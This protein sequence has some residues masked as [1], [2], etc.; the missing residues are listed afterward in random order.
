MPPEQPRNIL[1]EVELVDRANPYVD[2]KREERQFG[3]ETHD[4]I[5]GRVAK[6]TLGSTTVLH[7][8]GHGNSEVIYSGDGPN[9]K[10]FRVTPFSPEARNAVPMPTT[11]NVQGNHAVLPAN[12][13]FGPDGLDKGDDYT[14][15]NR[16]W[17]A[18]K[19][20]IAKGPRT[21][22]QFWGNKPD[23][24]SYVHGP[25]GI[26]PTDAD[27]EIETSTSLRAA[28]KTD[29]KD[30]EGA[31]KQDAETTGQVAHEDIEAAE[32]QNDDEQMLD[33]AAAVSG[34]IQAIP[35]QIPDA[36]LRPGHLK[37]TVHEDLPD[38]PDLWWVVTS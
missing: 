32:Q 10:V 30:D 36:P 29:P 17:P 35:S 21:A 7:L 8:P 27:E 16:L 1:T 24:G 5:M 20:R 28:A 11:G 19:S 15:N 34:D 31:S 14:N 13:N 3:S 23:N 2:D 26:E 9:G 37:K 18:S 4:A 6:M 25:F 33:G 22:D 12:L 38:L